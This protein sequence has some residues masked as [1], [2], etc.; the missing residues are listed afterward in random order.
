MVNKAIIVIIVSLNKFKKKK[1]SECS[2]NNCML[3]TVHF[4]MLFL[5]DI[6]KSTF[7]LK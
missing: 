7:N 5:I 2:S 1:A 4:D 6:I 3:A